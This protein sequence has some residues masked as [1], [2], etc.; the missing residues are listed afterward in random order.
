MPDQEGPC[1]TVKTFMG[2]LSKVEVVQL[3]VGIAFIDEFF[4][5][6]QHSEHSDMA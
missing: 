6:Q 2:P 1:Y 3:S 5:S 4:V